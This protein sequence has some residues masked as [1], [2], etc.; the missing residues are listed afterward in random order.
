MYPS[1]PE[2]D[3]QVP[4]AWLSTLQ[5]VYTYNMWWYYSG[6]GDGVMVQK[7]S[8]RFINVYKMFL[9]RWPGRKKRPTEIVGR[10]DYAFSQTEKRRLRRI[11]V[12]R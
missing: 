2:N 1:G 6:G 3:K 10:T 12:G 9:F 11:F 7:P 8:K 4:V 5:I